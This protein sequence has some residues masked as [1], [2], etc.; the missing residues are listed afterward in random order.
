[1]ET[2]APTIPA[3][4]QPRAA[5]NAWSALPELTRPGL[6]L[7]VWSNAIAGWW[8]GGGGPAPVVPWVFAGLTLIFL[9]GALLHDAFDA[10]WDALHAPQRPIPSG[11][12]RYKIVWRAGLVLASAGTVVLIS[13][14]PVFAALGLTLVSAA[15]LYNAL[16]RLRAAAPLLMG[17]GRL[18][19]YL[20]GAAAGG[21][22][23]DGLAIWSGL[24]MAAYAAG[25]EEIRRAAASR[26][27]PATPPVALLAAPIGLAFLVNAGGY[28]ATAAWLSLVLAVWLGVSLRGVLLKRPAN[29]GSLARL[30]SGMIPADWL[31]ALTAPRGVALVFLSLWLLSLA[32][33][34]PRP[35]PGILAQTIFK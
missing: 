31:A 6:L 34:R 11:R 23:I 4:S 18:T 2:L 14:G 26:R 13:R 33:L 15:I 30:R 25:V 24:A 29:T 35:G 21:W 20:L 16:H 27:V 10:E 12:I 22:G 32:R 17:L 8:L 5:L 7:T 3:P 28:R 1:M 19:V 9:G